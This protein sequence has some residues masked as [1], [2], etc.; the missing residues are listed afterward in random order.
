MSTEKKKKAHWKVAEFTR[1]EGTR[2]VREETEEGSKGGKNN[3]TNKDGMADLLSFSGSTYLE[4]ENDTCIKDSFKG[5]ARIVTLHKD[6][7]T[8]PN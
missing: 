3:G 2:K 5:T 1:V 6:L 8:R 4:E 7:Y